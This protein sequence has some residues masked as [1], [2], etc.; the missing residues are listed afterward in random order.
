MRKL[1]KKKKILMQEDHKIKTDMTMLFVKACSDFS[2]QEVLTCF[3]QSW[4][5]YLTEW[6]TSNSK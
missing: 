1:L 5:L 2:F 3:P 6:H 4:E